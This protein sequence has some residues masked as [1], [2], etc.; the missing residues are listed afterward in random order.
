MAD[1]VDRARG[2]VS[3]LIKIVMQVNIELMINEREILQKS[4]IFF[5]R[6]DM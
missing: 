3:S 5:P 2:I 4:S 6:I 1:I